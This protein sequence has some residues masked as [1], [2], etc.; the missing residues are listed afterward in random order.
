[1]TRVRVYR[2]ITRV[3]GTK[4]QSPRKKNNRIKEMKHACNGFDDAERRSAARVTRQCTAQGLKTLENSHSLCL[5]V[6]MHACIYVR[7]YHTYLCMEAERARERESERARER[8]S[9]REREKYRER[10]RE[11]ERERD[12]CTYTYIYTYR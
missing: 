8:E 3:R 2:Y 7:M 10:E 5:Y 6:C 12:V 9:E 11:R 4:H 1:M